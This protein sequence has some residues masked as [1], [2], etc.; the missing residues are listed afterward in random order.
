MTAKSHK[1][2]RKA[3]VW[4]IVE[5]ESESESESDSDPGGLNGPPQIYGDPLM[6]NVGW[7]CW[8]NQFGHP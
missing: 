3:L 6:E 5:S 7:L 1:N 8:G 4:V 2:F